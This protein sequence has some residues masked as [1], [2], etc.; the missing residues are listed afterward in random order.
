MFLAILSCS[1][2][3]AIQWNSPASDADTYGIV[4]LEIEVRMA[5]D[6]DRVEPTN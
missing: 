6:V 1:E 3:E 5:A 2:Q 4:R